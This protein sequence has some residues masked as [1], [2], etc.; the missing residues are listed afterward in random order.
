M[1]SW[2]HANKQESGNKSE[3]LLTR[4][5]VPVEGKSML[6]NTINFLIL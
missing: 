3:I 4:L 2:V 5:V 6:V 1:K